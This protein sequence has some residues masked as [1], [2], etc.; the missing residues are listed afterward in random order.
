VQIEVT[1]IGVLYLAMFRGKVNLYIPTDFKDFLLW[2]KN[3]TEERW[4]DGPQTDEDACGWDRHESFWGSRW[5]GGLTH[6]EINEIEKKWNVKFPPD[7]Q[8]F[9]EILHTIDRKEV[10]EQ[11]DWET[12]E[13]ITYEKPFFYNWKTDTTELESRFS[14]PFRTILEDIEGANRVWLRSWGERPKE[15][16]VRYSKFKQW[17]DQA[18]SLIPVTGHRF[19]IADPAVSGNPILSV[20]GSDIILYGWNLRHYLLNELSWDLGLHNVTIDYDDGSYDHD[21]LIPAY[22][23]I[24]EK[25]MKLGDHEKL[26]SWKEIIM[27]WS[28]NGASIGLPYETSSSGPTPIVAIGGENDGQQKIFNSFDE[29]DK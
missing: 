4:A 1:L 16:K 18:P 3:R 11:T 8:L 22:K 27:Y 26:S 28:C 24:I 21:E 12:D 25:E 10:I 20:W 14:W 13:I 2:V 17:F 23:E 29:K 9:L 19:I 15:A 5:T 6:H 7:F